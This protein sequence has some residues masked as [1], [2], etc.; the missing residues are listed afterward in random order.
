MM[1]FV[2]PVPLHR[3]GHNA[4]CGLAS[5]AM[6]LTHAGID[7]TVPDLEKHPLVLP[8]MLGGWG[9]GPGRLGRIA[10]SFG[11]PVTLIDSEARDVGKRFV[12]MGGEWVR[13][14]PTKDDILAW[15]ARGVA[16]VV[17]IPDKTKAFP[18][19]SHHGSHWVTAIGVE[20]GEIRI[21]DPAPW[22]KAERCAPGYWD[23]WRC[24]L[25]AI[26]PKE[27]GNGNGNGH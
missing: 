15:L 10:R 14:E 21:H 8:Q 16:P 2:L 22:R 17:C 25:I 18:G 13:R 26:Q 9:I 12:A 4:G 5:I 1:D 7:V 6:A 24:S 20:G 11:V 27:N 19:T 23:E 3:Q